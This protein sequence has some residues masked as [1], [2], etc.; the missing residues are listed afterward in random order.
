M[1]DGND[2]WKPNIVNSMVVVFLM[3]LRIKKQLKTNKIENLRFEINC[4]VTVFDFFGTT[5]GY[6]RAVPP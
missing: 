6:S 1:S 3:F 4:F 5:T 2:F